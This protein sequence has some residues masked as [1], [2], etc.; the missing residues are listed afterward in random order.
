MSRWA[1]VIAAVLAGAAAAC[2]LF[3]GWLM[4]PGG[5]R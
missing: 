4:S 5:P 2:V 3:Y 1:P